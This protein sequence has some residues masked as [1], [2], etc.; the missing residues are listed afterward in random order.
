MSEKEPILPTS[1]HLHVK[2]TYS[3]KEDISNA[4]ISKEVQ[5]LFDKEK[6]NKEEEDLFP[7]Y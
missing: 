4:R 7:D 1:I 5:A 2:P 3:L 6:Q